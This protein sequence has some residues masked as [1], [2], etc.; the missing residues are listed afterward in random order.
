M[1]ITRRKTKIIQLLS[2]AKNMKLLILIQY[3]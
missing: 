1:I 2:K 3:F